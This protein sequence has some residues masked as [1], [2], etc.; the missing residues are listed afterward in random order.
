MRAAQM[1]RQR[2]HV[3]EIQ[4]QLLAC[5]PHV[6]VLQG[7]ERGGGA[8]IEEGDRRPR[9]LPLR[10]RHHRP[11]ARQVRRQRIRRVGERQQVVALFDDAAQVVEA[12]QAVASSPAATRR[13]RGSRAPGHRTP[14]THRT[15][16][17][18][19]GSR[20]GRGRAVRR[21]RRYAARCVASPLIGRTPMPGTCA[22]FGVSDAS[23]TASSSLTM[24][25]PIARP[26]RGRRRRSSPLRPSRRRRGRP[27]GG[28][29]SA[30]WHG[31]PPWMTPVSS[32]GRPLAVAAADAPGGDLRGAGHHHL[33]A[34]L[35]RLVR[36]E[37][38][39]VLR[40]GAHVDGEDAHVV[41]MRARSD[42]GHWRLSGERRDRE[43]KMEDGVE[44]DA[45][46]G[47]P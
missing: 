32:S 18:P 26:A 3:A 9:I 29:S 4:H 43:L 15:P 16:R 2:V 41:S 46:V 35:D 47:L 14:A 23:A 22:R 31:P 36:I 30:Q 10:R 1:E 13:G 12:E 27:R 7:A 24:W 39:D 20:R 5:V 17:A 37:Q 42:T 6:R 34:V 28:R 33:D 19:C 8:G 40:A 44:D 11:R 45:P 25:I 21:A 38:Q